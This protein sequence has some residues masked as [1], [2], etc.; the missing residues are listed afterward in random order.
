MMDLRKKVAT[1]AAEDSRCDIVYLADIASLRS[2]PPNE[3]EV[4]AECENGFRVRID[5]QG[6][7]MKGVK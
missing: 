7:V 1:A 4:Y 2:N 3:I 5:K 6:K